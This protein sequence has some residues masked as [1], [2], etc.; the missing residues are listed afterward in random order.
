MT[1]CSETQED[2]LNQWS[3]RLCPVLTLHAPLWF[4]CGLLLPLELKAALAPVLSNGP[5]PSPSFPLCYTSP[6]LS[7]VS[8]L[9]IHHTMLL[10][11]KVCR[12]KVYHV[13]RSPCTQ[14]EVFTA[15]PG[16]AVPFCIFVFAFH[17]AWLFF[18]GDFGYNHCTTDGGTLNQQ[19]GLQM[20]SKCV[21]GQK[22]QKANHLMVKNRF[23]K[24]QKAI[25]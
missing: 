25:S 8:S 19:R 17:D 1:W 11:F 22:F 20:C 12:N 23:R 6:F 21:T 24:K 15:C 3:H 16:P 4:P 14:H 5:P 9:H 2:L 18:L 7:I 10:M 13:F